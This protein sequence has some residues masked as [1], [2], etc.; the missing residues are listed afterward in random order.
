MS[1]TLYSP[2]SSVARRLVLDVADDSEYQ[3]SS[4]SLPS[5]RFLIET[6]A[7]L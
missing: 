2:N 7:P 5:Q 3:P 4:C 1:R 6:V